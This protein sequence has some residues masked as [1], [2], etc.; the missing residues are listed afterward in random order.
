MIASEV[1]PRVFL[2]LELEGIT[3]A[4]VG[5]IRLI[6]G[7]A[8]VFL[9]LRVVGRRFRDIGLVSAH[10]TGDLAIGAS[11]AVAFALIQFLVIIRNTGGAGRSDVAANAAQ[12]GTSFLGVPGFVILAWT[13]AF[14]EE[15]F[16][17]GHFF[18]ALR[19]LL[20]PSRLALVV[21]VAATV[22]LFAA[23]HGYQGWAGI[24]DTGFYGGLT[25]TVLFVWRRRLTPCIVAHALWNT[26]ATVVIYWWY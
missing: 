14:S 21:A 19:K 10:L 23:G 8:A 22:V 6:L 9:A 20:G 24:V 2:G 17:R 4:L 26:L 25:L 12:I 15:L 18:T 5:L 16:F 7:G 11:V 3:Y 13:G 1:I